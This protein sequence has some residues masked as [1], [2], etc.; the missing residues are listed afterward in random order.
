MLSHKKFKFNSEE[1]N[2]HIWNSMNV[3]FVS[4]S[5]IT[6]N[7]NFVNRSRENRLLIISIF[8]T[9]L[10][11]RADDH[12]LPSATGGA[13]NL[14]HLKQ[15]LG[16]CTVS[17][18]PTMCF[19]VSNSIYLILNICQLI[20]WAIWWDCDKLYFLC[21]AISYWKGRLSSEDGASSEDVLA[22]H[23]SSSGRQSVW[24]KI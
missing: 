16:C 11:L 24:L 4:D 14:E 23:G 19:Q 1:I 6:F 9:F 20:F 18:Y 22:M 2:G 3:K 17:V 12:K 13:C 8:E 7:R 5:C 21:Y 10:G 15:R